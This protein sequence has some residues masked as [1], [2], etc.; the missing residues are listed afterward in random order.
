MNMV[1]HQAE[2]VDQKLHRLRCSSQ[3]RDCGVAAAGILKNSEAV[4]AADC[5][6]RNRGTNVFVRRKAN[7]F[8]RG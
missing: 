6:E 1:R 4:F 5:D 3:Y 2:R 8:S 7:L